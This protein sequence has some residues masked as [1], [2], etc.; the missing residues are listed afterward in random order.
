[1]NHATDRISILLA[2]KK[3]QYRIYSHEAVLQP[4]RGQARKSCQQKRKERIQRWSITQQAT[5]L[6]RSSTSSLWYFFL[7]FIS[8][9]YFL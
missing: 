5:T 2:A 3:T 7:N 8:F 4:V 1:M 9:L 6:P